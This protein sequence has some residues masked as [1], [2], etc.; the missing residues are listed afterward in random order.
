M[1]SVFVVVLTS[2]FDADVSADVVVRTFVSRDL[3]T[4]WVYEAQLRA[5]NW[6]PARI[7]IRHFEVPAPTADSHVDR[8]GLRREW[9]SGDDMYH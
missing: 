4:G 7:V 5:L 2:H 8:G 1:F 6:I 9:V 3:A